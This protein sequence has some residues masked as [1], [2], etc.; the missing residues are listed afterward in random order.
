MLPRTTQVIA[1]G[2]RVAPI[3]VCLFGLGACSDGLFATATPTATPTLRPTSTP[4]KVPTVPPRAT[5]TPPPAVTSSPTPDAAATATV[6][7]R[8]A[9]CESAI[10]VLA[11]RD[12][13]PA[14]L[15]NP[16][17]VALAT[18]APDLVVCGAVATDTVARC[19]RLMPDD[20]GP[21]G[22]CRALVS[23]FH[24]LKTHP[25][26]HSFL[27]TEDDGKELERISVP[28]PAV[29]DAV[30]KAVRAGDPKECAAAG[31]LASVCRAFIDLDPAHC[32]VEGS[33]KDVRVEAPKVAG[34]PKLGSLLADFCKENITSRRFLAQGLKALAESGP[35]RE[36]DLARAALGGAD[37]CAPYAESAMQLCMGAG[38]AAGTPVAVPGGQTPAVTGTPGSSGT[39][40]GSKAPGAG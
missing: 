15:D 29:W 13:N 40:P 16:E 35:P 36:R 30:R 32:R 25:K 37:A 28:P 10:T 26:S 21:G 7:A 33:L 31:D 22:A 14:A 27:I 12:T 18:G 2:V 34:K 9:A 20:R 39:A 3:V 17:V 38:A 24:E 19:T 11:G 23:V 5:D 4:T 1:R 8:R 6:A